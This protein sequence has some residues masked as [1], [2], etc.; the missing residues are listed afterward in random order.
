[1]EF[2]VTPQSSIQFEGDTTQH[3]YVKNHKRRTRREQKQWY[4]QQKEQ[5]EYY[6][7]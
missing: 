2:Q 7:Y 6:Q 5:R 3:P 4:K 1:M